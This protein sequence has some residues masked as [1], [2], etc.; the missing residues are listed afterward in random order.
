MI[1]QFNLKILGHD[2]I[3]DQHGELRCSEKVRVRAEDVDLEFSTGDM[4]GSHVGELREINLCEGCYEIIVRTLLA[5]VARLKAKKCP[6]DLAKEF[7]EG[8]D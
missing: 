3:I 6:H 2:F 4:M 8:F 7:L 1:D 5:E